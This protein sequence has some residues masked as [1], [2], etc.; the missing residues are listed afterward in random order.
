MTYRKKMGQIFRELDEIPYQVQWEVNKSYSK[1]YQS[2]FKKKE[3]TEDSKVSKVSNN[4][5]WVTTEDFF[6]LKGHLRTT[7]NKLAV[8]KDKL[9]SNIQGRE[10]KIRLGTLSTAISRS[11][12]KHYFHQDKIITSSGIYHGENECSGI[13]TY[14]SYQDIKY[15]SSTVLFS[16]LSQEN[17]LSNISVK[18]SRSS[19]SL[20]QPSSKLNISDP[21]VD[22]LEVQ[23]DIDRI[24]NTSNIGPKTKPNKLQ[25]QQSAIYSYMSQEQD[26]TIKREQEFSI[27]TNFNLED[28]GQRFD[29]VNFLKAEPNSLTPNKKLSSVEAEKKYLLTIQSSNVLKV[30]GIDVSKNDRVKIK[31]D[32]CSID[33]ELFRLL[34]QKHGHIAEKSKVIKISQNQLKKSPTYLTQDL[35]ARSRLQK[36]SNQEKR[37]EEV[38]LPSKKDGESNFQASF[39]EHEG[40]EPS[41]RNA[42]GLKSIESASFLVSKPLSKTEAH[43]LAPCSTESILDDSHEC[44]NPSFFPRLKFPPLVINNNSPIIGISSNNCLRT[45]FHIQE[46][47]NEAER[48]MRLNTAP[49]I[50]LFARTVYS[51]R[52]PRTTRQKFNFSDLW[53]AKPPFLDGILLNF[54]ATKMIEKESR[55]FTETYSKPYLARILATP[56]RVIVEDIMSQ[57]TTSTASSWSL[58]IISIRKTDFE[59][60]NST[61][62]ILKTCS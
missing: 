2:K 4:H 31:N 32:S 33:G 39:Q 34:D 29:D 51:Y 27:S 8:S 13:I 57:D 42:S 18:E 16:F 22:R 30:S 56:K 49:V 11:Q 21:T 7:I 15:R 61:R 45:C 52:E 25:D 12:I 58:H 17:N 23:A 55:L 48:F 41:V 59:E 19:S 10:D 5:G 44:I 35:N 54:K 37:I 20:M 40:L 14:P 3:F 1:R 9:L 24:I 62:R 53:H 50:E 46:V 26:I 47:I 28:S 60:I 6:K 38:L 36:I 43:Q